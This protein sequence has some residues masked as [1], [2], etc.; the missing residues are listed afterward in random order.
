MSDDDRRPDLN[1]ATVPLE[2]ALEAAGLGFSDE[3]ELVHLVQPELERRRLRPVSP[4]V[5]VEHV[6]EPRVFERGVPVE[7]THYYT[8]DR[9]GR[10]TTADA[11]PPGVRRLVLC[12]PR[13]R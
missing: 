7:P 9:C 2:A 11:A 12:R 6:T 13:C 1:F 10:F 5:R 8:C 3:S 4:A